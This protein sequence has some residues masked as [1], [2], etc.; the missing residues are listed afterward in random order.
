MSIAVKCRHLVELMIKESIEQEDM[1]MMIWWW[2]TLGDIQQEDLHTSSPLH[3]DTA[4][5][6]LMNRCCTEKDHKAIRSCQRNDDLWTRRWR[7]IGDERAFRS[8]H[9][10]L[11][12]Q[13]QQYQRHYYDNCSP[14]FS[15]SFA[16]L[17]FCNQVS[18]VFFLGNII[19]IIII[20]SSSSSSSSQ[21]I[22]NK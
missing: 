22:I 9:E 12:W 2:K 13:P 21:I 6:T 8:A 5:R 16:E 19:I 15:F 1:T 3:D 20:I 10:S 17:S 4:K 14:P 11:G 7:A 18:E